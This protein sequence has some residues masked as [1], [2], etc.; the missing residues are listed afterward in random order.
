M[1]TTILE[2]S[3]A[4]F[5]GGERRGQAIS[6]YDILE[7]L[8]NALQTVLYGIIRRRPKAT[9]SDR[10]YTDNAAFWA[11]AF[12]TKHFPG[13]NIILEDFHLTEWLPFAPGRYFD[14]NVSG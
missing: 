2:R 14:P 4:P 12:A 3:G 5:R 6:R 9:G 8:A 1:S 10:T 7:H 13:S 11:D